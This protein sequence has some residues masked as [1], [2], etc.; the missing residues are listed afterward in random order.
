MRDF[1]FK[2]SWAV[3]MIVTLLLSVWKAPR[4][5]DRVF[6]WIPR[7]PTRAQWAAPLGLAMLAALGQGYLDGVRGEALLEYCAAQ[8]G[9]VG[10]MAIGLWHCYKRVR[11]TGLGGT[12]ATLALLAV[13]FSTQGCSNLH[14][15]VEKALVLEQQVHS[16]ALNLRVVA[17]AAIPLLPVEQ[18][19]AA[20]EQLAT[21]FERL[22]KAMA[23]KDALLQAAL[24]SSASE[25]DTAA[26]VAQIVSAIRDIVSLV[27]SFGVSE[28]Q[29]APINSRA[30]ALRVEV[31]Q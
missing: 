14:M 19:Q 15:S 22:T 23:A 24:T 28:R 18:Q 9:Q 30:M 1:F 21:G 2:H 13:S 11:G 12:V 7:L 17:D 16:E 27:Q 26:T 5:R 29:M 8:G 4:L 20:R 3:A 31:V 10:V 25:V 6:A